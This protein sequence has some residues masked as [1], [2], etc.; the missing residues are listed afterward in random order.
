MCTN[1]Y[2]LGTYWCTEWGCYEMDDP[3]FEELRMKKKKK[4]LQCRLAV[5]AR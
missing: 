4:N 2:C 1:P 3:E 5:E